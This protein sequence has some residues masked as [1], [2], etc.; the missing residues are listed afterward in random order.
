M[1]SFENL[2]LW[3]NSTW[4]CVIKVCS[5]GYNNYTKLYDITTIVH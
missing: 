3:K 2:L 4:V 1:P 5:N